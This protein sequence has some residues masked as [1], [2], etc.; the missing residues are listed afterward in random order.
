MVCGLWF[1][2]IHG[3]FCT[4][5]HGCVYALSFKCGVTVIE[6]KQGVG[7]Q[8]RVRADSARKAPAAYYL[9]AV[10]ACSCRCEAVRNR[11]RPSNSVHIGQACSGLGVFLSPNYDGWYG[12]SARPLT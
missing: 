1:P 8:S 12:P 2:Y 7:R 6:G 9:Q 4:H 5:I 11:L 10:S 3:T